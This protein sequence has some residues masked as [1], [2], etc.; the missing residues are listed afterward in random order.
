V[1]EKDEFLRIEPQAEKYFRPWMGFDEFLNRYFRYC[2]WLGDATP[3]E[4][5]KMPEVMKRIDAVRQFRLASKSEGTRKI[6]AKPRRFH[7]ENMPEAA[8]KV[9]SIHEFHEF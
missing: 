6:A 4:L 8:S 7:V 3:N 9:F 2:L 1:S 5:R